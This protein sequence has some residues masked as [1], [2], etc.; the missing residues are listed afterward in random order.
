MLTLR[1]RIVLFWVIILALILAACAPSGEAPGTGNGPTPAVTP[2][3]PAATPTGPPGAGNSLAN[4]AWV[5]VSYGAPGAETPVVAGSTVTLEFEAGDQAGGSAGCNSYG[6]HYR[7][8]GDA[9]SF[10]EMVQTLMACED[11]QVMEQEAQYLAALETASQFELSGD[12]LAI[13]YDGGQGV[14]NFVRASD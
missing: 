14:L 11:E 7:V 13:T 4:T 5:L 1:G 9:I 8:D 6:G 3:G 10:S 2:T 12:S